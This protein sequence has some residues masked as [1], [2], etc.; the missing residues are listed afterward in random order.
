MIK[1][2]KDERKA[3]PEPEWV[4]EVH[5][6]EENLFSILKQFIYEFEQGEN[7]FNTVLEAKEL[8]KKV[9]P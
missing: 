8:L 9:K 7:S 4:E 1:N 6:Y 3:F 2:S 5:D